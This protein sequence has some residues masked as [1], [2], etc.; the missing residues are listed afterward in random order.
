MSSRTA[1][2]SSPA[3]MVIRLFKYQSRLGGFDVRK[4]YTLLAGS[5]VLTGMT[6]VGCGNSSGGQAANQSDKTIVIALGADNTGLDP[7]SVMNNE[8]GYVMS[9]IYDELVEYKPGTTEIGPG[10]ADNWDISTDGLTYT[11]HLHKGVKFQDGTSCNA[12]AIVQWLDRLLNSNNPNYYA[13]RKGIDSYV[14]FTFHGVDKYTKVDDNT[15]QIHM[16]KPNA[17]F[18]NS[19]A[20]VWMGVTS[21]DA[22]KKWGQDYYKHPVGTGP[23]KFVEW[24]SNDHVTLTAN[25]DYWKEKPKVSKIVYRIIP[26]SSVRVLELKKGTVDVLAD[27]A[28]SDANTLKQDSSVNVLEQ[29]GLMVDGVSLPTQVKPFNDP[30]V[31]QALNYAINKDDLNQYLYK[32]MATTMNSPLPPVE[33]SY[34]KSLPAYSYDV[35]KAKGLLTQAGYPSGFTATL[36]VYPNPRSYNPVGGPQLAQALQADLKKVGVT[37][38]IQQIEWGAFLAKVR[39]KDFGDMALA[40]WSGDNGDPD[41]FLDSLWGTDQIP[42]GNEAHYTNKQLDDLLAKALQST[43]QSERTDLYK[44]AQKTLHDDAPWIFLNYATQIRAT[45]AKVHGLV[46][47]PTGMFFG[48]EQVSKD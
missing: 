38:N 41:N 16:T 10:L 42:S 9:A 48:L 30:R 22:V 15:V 32:G 1:T 19:L 33:W 12:D 24:V 28:P 34:D 17:E 46:L 7:E 2:E 21:P 8:S 45:S 25:A 40:G 39:S 18:L 36:Y 13:N 35:E 31:R 27:V 11:F 47:N 26:E 4:G 23:F 44:Q 29:P 6:L 20:M 37:I 14:D 3:A 5:I 43:D